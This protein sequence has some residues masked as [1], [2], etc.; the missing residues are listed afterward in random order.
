[1][2][3]SEYLRLNHAGS[4][5]AFAKLLAVP[6]TT[7]WRIATGQRK[8]RPETVELILRATKG[9]VTFADLSA[10]EKIYQPQSRRKKR[11]RAKPRG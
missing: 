9:A 8:P 4:H 2:Q 5:R 6:P 7:I 3:L 10:I 11:K 1:M